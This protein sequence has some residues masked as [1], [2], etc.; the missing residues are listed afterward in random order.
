MVKL[1]F[2]ISCPEMEPGKKVWRGWTF[3]IQ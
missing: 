3:F 1:Y 2:S